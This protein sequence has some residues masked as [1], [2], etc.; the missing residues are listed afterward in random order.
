L[1]S[2][3]APIITTGSAYLPGMAPGASYL[4]QVRGDPIMAGYISFASSLFQSAI[5]LPDPTITYTITGPGGVALSQDGLS[6]T[7]MS[8]VGTFPIALPTSTSFTLYNMTVTAS[9][10][11]NYST[12]KIWTISTFPL[13][14]PD[15]TSSF[16]CAN[17]TIWISGTKVPPIVCTFLARNQNNVIATLPS[18][19][20]PMLVNNADGSVSAGALSSVVSTGS[21]LTRFVNILSCSFSCLFV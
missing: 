10:T 12:S 4:T 5:S 2:S 15:A 17:R 21:A 8:V 11:C 19:I 16:S 14:Q 6:F 9:N 20:T 3:A 1:L 7:Q 13:M 18:Y